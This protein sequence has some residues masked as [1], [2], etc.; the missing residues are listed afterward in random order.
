MVSTSS[1]SPTFATV[2]PSLMSKSTSNPPPSMALIPFTDNQLTH[3]FI[4]FYCCHSIM[5]FLLLLCHLP[6]PVQNRHSTTVHAHESPKYNE[7]VI[8]AV[9]WRQ[10]QLLTSQILLWT[11]SCFKPQNSALLSKRRKSEGDLEGAQ[12]SYWDGS[13]HM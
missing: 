8:T 9:G 10:K 2:R 7:I 4:S 1:S 13:W 12:I 11:R 3:R 6:L 5:S